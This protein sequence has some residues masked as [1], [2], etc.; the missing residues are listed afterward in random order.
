MKKR[1][2]NKGNISV[3][4][5]TLVAIAWMSF[6]ILYEPDFYLKGVMAWCAVACIPII[7]LASLITT[8]EFVRIT[9]FR[10][11]EYERWKWKINRYKKYYVVETVTID[12]E[13]V[14][15]WHIRD[16]EDVMDK[17]KLDAYTKNT[18]GYEYKEEAMIDIIEEVKQIVADDKQA[19]GI[20]IRNVRT[21]EVFTVDDLKTR[22][23]AGE[24]E[25]LK[26]N[27]RDRKEKKKK[28]KEKK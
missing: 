12:A 6:A 8:D 11:H 28:K 27:L 23:D 24:F 5:W 25:N 9:E 3:W 26:A 14:F 15:H 19:E 18:L 10:I 4:L 13:F 2:R 22:L 7:A 1:R 20:R 16:H 17:D 21:L